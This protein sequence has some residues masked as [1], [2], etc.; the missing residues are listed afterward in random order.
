MDFF[1]IN[2]LRYNYDI[3]LKNYEYGIKM[4]N[5]IEPLYYQY[6]ICILN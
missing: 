5:I 1:K 6:I 4:V 2:I 3:L